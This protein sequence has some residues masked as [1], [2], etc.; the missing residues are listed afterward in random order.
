[1]KI[2]DIIA[3]CRDGEIYSEQIEWAGR[4]YE[5]D[6]G[7][8]QYPAT[9][10]FASGANWHDDRDK[11]ALCGTHTWGEVVHEDDSYGERCKRC[12]R[13][14]KALEEEEERQ[15]LVE[16]DDIVERNSGFKSFNGLL[17]AL[18]DYRPTIDVSV[19]EK[20]YLADEYDAAQAER[21]DERRAFRRG[22]P[23]HP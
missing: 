13:L 2:K 19:P 16:L 20:E 22:G 3:A 15:K 7:A 17:N 12:I 6:N 11:T 14:V 8:L 4:I 18:G 1:M 21:G 9:H 5:D 10:A 23:L